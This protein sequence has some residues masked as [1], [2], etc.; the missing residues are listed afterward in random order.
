MALKRGSYGRSSDTVN[1]G[2]NILKDINRMSSTGETAAAPGTTDGTAAK[3]A[4][5]TQKPFTAEQI[6]ADPVLS[7]K[8]TL[9]QAKINWL[10]YQD[11]LNKMP[12]ATT[13]GAKYDSQLKA[14]QAALA[15][16]GG[17]PQ[18]AERQFYALGGK[19]V[20]TKQGGGAGWSENQILNYWRNAGMEDKGYEIVSKIRGYDRFGNPVEGGLSNNTINYTLGDE[21][22]TNVKS[23]VKGLSAVQ[24]ARLTKLRN[25]KQG[26]ATL[27]PKQK[28][29]LKKLKALAQG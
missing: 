19:M 5:K 16:I 21:Y 13:T 14:A 24:A 25:L 4:R 12:L 2:A 23:D 20:D 17:N 6:A 8:I 11:A 28:A 29:K 9:D 15:K 3:P 18:E 10:K 27:G 26:G 22:Q 7:G 1:Y